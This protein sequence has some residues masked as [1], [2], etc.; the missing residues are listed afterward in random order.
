MLD[1][2][3]LAGGQGTRLREVIKDVPKPMAKINNVPFL[4]ILISK[5]ETCP[6]INKIILAI[7]YKSEKI[8]DYYTNSSCKKDIHFSI[9][10]SPLGT[11]GALK[12]AFPLTNTEN[13]LV[14]NG[15]SFL[16][17]NLDDFTDFH[18]TKKSKLSIAIKEKNDA[19]RY[20]KIILSKS[21][22]II[23]FQEKANTPS[24]G[25]INAGIYIFNR[26]IFTSFPNKETFS[27]E[28]DFFSALAQNFSFG[29]PCN[30]TFIDIGTKNSYHNAQKILSEFTS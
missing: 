27:L 1:A 30:K 19:S 29:F 9:E 8:T 2:I 10:Q 18:R 13:I 24:A 23:Y 28:N 5:L 22:K 3:I 14:L 15:D 4:D 26:E 25:F 11:G 17:I 7:G 16:D 6:K 20:G 21:N 12:K